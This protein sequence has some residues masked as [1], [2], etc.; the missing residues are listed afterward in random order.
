MKDPTPN[1]HTFLLFHCKEIFKRDCPVRL[2]IPTDKM[3]MALPRMMAREIRWN[4]YS[5][6][7]GSHLRLAISMSED[8]TRYP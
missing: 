8:V 2:M 4:N 7:R 6:S 5:D 1:R 3:E